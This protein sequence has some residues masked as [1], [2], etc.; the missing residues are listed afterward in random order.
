M[1]KIVD[2][3]AYSKNILNHFIK[4]NNYIYHIITLN[5]DQISIYFKTI[6]LYLN[7][8]FH[9]ENSNSIN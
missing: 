1:E 7:L 2:F 8:V 4:E 3:D 9:H 5:K 6:S